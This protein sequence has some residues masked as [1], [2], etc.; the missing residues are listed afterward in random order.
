MTEVEAEMAGQVA[1]GSRA[2]VA[3]R[4]DVAV[5]A[6]RRTGHGVEEGLATLV[7]EAAGGRAHP[8]RACEQLGDRYPVAVQQELGPREQDPFRDQR[9]EPGNRGYQK[10][11]STSRPRTRVGTATARATASSTAI[12]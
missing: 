4:G 8:V 9:L 5:P 12:R 7:G 2:A 1:D 6:D 11:P 10:T 3:A